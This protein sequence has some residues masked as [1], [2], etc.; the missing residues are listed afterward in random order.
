ML[1]H[2]FAVGLAI[3]LLPGNLLA[4]LLGTA[5]GIVVG[6]LPGLSATMA[7]ALLLPVT[8]ATGPIA[9]LIMLSGIYA[10]AIY[11][12][13][14]SAVL[15]GTPGTGASVVTVWDGYP[16]TKRGESRLALATVTW[17]S[18]FGG[19]AGGL[20]LIFLAPP[21]AALALIFGAPDYTALVLFSMTLLVSMSGDEPVKGV[22]IG[23]FG[24]LIGTI[25]LDPVYG[26][27]RFT[28]GFGELAGG[29]SFISVL[30]GAFSMPQA[31]LLA[32][33]A[34]KER[35]VTPVAPIIGNERLTLSNMRGQFLNALR[36]SA[37]GI[38]IGILPGI[39]PETSPFIAYEEAKRFSK[40]PERFGTGIIDGLVASE[41]TNNATVGGSLIPLLTLGIP[42]SAAAA[43]YVGALTLHGLQ[44][45]PMLFAQRADIV[46]T[47]FIGFLICNCMLLGLGLGGVRLWTRVLALPKAIVA[48]LIVVF[49]AVGSYAI[50]NSVFD[51][52]V[53]VIA[54][55]VAYVLAQHRF[56]LGALALG[57]ILGPIFEENLL[58]SLSLSQNSWLTFVQH[59]IS[60]VFLVLA[61]GSLVW[62]IRKAQLRAHGRLRSGPGT[63]VGESMD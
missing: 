15:I 3:A 10:G 52:W 5:G 26:V 48:I 33:A 4:A 56:P 12:G 8:Y 58:R 35:A 40:H 57:M 2:N 31:L 24:C 43:V 51:L 54:G 27:P 60:L 44:P 20:V 41:A 21:L 7:V 37:I 59:P 19:M 34:L 46:Y 45:G 23:L 1:L 32:A 42:G 25:G 13:S 63:T 62:S 28:F 53:T 17:A 47:L 14:V 50:R 36:S 18:F 9:G 29:I 49:S 6:V 55:G 22:I 39:G 11:G 16:M 38:W 30:I 61:L